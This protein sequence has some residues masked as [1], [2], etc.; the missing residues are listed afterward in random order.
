MWKPNGDESRN[1]LAGGRSYSLLFGRR[2]TLDG[3]SLGIYLSHL[4]LENF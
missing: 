1:N 2:L 3:F 4:D